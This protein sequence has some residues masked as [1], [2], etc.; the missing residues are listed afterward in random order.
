MVTMEV[1]L[2]KATDLSVVSR[3]ASGVVAADTQVL[4]GRAH[5]HARHVLTGMIA[6]FVNQVR[7]A[8]WP[9]LQCL[10]IKLRSRDIILH[11]LVHTGDSGTQNTDASLILA[12][13]W[14]S[15]SISMSCKLPVRCVLITESELFSCL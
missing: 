15:C 11:H 14:E 7:M 8:G 4:A 6:M 2:L 3:G 12:M 9:V 10:K 13:S 5:R 1:G